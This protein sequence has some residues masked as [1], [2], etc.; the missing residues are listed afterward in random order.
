MLLLMGLQ[1][2]LVVP[3]PAR[4]NSSC[5]ALKVKAMVDTRD[6][7]DACQTGLA[8]YPIVSVIGLV[9]FSACSLSS[10]NIDAQAL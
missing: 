8:E 3:Q 7:L 9:Q 6:G 1:E 4:A 2:C 5:L 10:F